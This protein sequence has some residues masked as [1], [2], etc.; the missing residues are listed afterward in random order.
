MTAL[1]AHHSHAP[2]SIAIWALV[3]A[4]WLLMFGAPFALRRVRQTRRTPHK[5]PVAAAVPVSEQPRD[6]HP[7]EGVVWPPPGE[8][9]LP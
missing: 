9:E 6:P 4:T 7:H 5:R 2:G 3:G 1:A 8:K